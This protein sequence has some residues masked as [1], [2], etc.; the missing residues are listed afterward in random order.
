MKLSFVTR[1]FSALVLCGLSCAVACSSTPDKVKDDSDDG[2]IG[3]RRPGGIFVLRRDLHILP[4]VDSAGIQGV[5]GERPSYF[6]LG[7]SLR[8]LRI[9]ASFRSH[10]L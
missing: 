3:G 6:T 9:L 5:T 2:P 1:T 8:P 4:R 10:F 7:G